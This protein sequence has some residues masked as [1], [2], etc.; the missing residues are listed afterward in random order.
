MSEEILQNYT[1]EAAHLGHLF[2]QI[3]MLREKIELLEKQFDELDKLFAKNAKF[4]LENLKK[5]D[6]M[7]KL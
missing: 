5:I 6:K 4:A 2:T 7:E 1:N 3:Q